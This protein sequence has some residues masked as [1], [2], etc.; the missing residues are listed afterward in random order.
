MNFVSKL[1]SLPNL[2]MNNF[3]SVFLASGEVTASFLES[4][5]F[6][7]RLL[8]VV[9]QFFYFATKWLMYMI[10]VIYFYVLQLVGVGSDTTIL[11]S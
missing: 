5:N 9:L 2:L 6:L 4:D 1:T 7:T 11:H 3:S 8:R 10:D